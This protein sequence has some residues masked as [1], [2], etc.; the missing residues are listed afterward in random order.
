[1]N[2]IIYEPRDTEETRNTRFHMSNRPVVI[3]GLCT[4][5]EACVSLCPEVFE[6][7]D[8]GKAHVKNPDAC[9]T[10]DCEGAVDIC[11]TEA[12]SWEER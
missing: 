6:M 2:R 12:I 7:D 10:C 9:N 4:G 11:P 5:C 8:Y 1:V 3:P